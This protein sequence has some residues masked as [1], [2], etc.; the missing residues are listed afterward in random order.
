MK[1]PQWFHERHRTQVV[2]GLIIY[3]DYKNG[4]RKCDLARKY[5]LSP[6]MIDNLVHRWHWREEHELEWYIEA[7]G[8]LSH[9]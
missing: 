4:M 5:A 9:E 8:W 7:K 1:T 2:R 6:T 3:E